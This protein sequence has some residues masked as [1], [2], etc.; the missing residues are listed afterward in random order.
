MKDKSL[1][2]L[3]GMVQNFEN[4]FA[5]EE[6]TPLER[7]KVKIEERR[8]EMLRHRMEAFKK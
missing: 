3:F 5:K 6:T 1:K 7:E 4:S 8:L 2:N